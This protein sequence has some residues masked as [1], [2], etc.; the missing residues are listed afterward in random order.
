MLSASSSRGLPPP[1]PAHGSGA[2]ASDGTTAGKPSS[3]SSSLTAARNTFVRLSDADA[4]RIL[5]SRKTVLNEE[6]GQMR[7]T[8][9]KL[10]G[11]A[12]KDVG[13]A[14]YLTARAMVR[15][16]VDGEELGYLRKAN[17]TVNKARELLSH[18]RGNVTTDLAKS[19]E[20]FWRTMFG[21]DRSTG[22]DLAT[23]TAMAV[24]MRAGNCGEHAN[25]AA[26][27][28]AGKLGD[29]EILQLVAGNGVDHA[30]AETRTPQGDRVIMD[31]WAQGPAVMA[32]DSAF[33]R[34]MRARK[35]LQD[36]SRADGRNF[37]QQTQD[38]LDSLLSDP[39]L[40]RSWEAF[41]KGAKKQALEPD[42]KSVFAP[43][44]VLSDKFKLEVNKAAAARIDVGQELQAVGAARGLGANVG[45]ALE[46]KD[47]ILTEMQKQTHV[48]KSRLLAQL[49]TRRA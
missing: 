4:G 43:T 44:P 7:R 16:S 21:R 40:E 32:E 46:A 45:Q 42:R 2:V 13:L 17:D 47:R 12:D 31:A 6:L 48:D 36:F 8:A 29:G 34:T 1:I 27:L 28:H 38:R 22:S 30:W 37:A 10:R 9:S 25:V 19:R 18:G 49:F 3:F 15:R 39:G 26:A 35:V 11:L 23:E 14:A 41:R 20:S 33:S 24:R 5:E